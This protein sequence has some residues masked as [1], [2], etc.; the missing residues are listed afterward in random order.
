MAEVVRDEGGE[1]GARSSTASEI[2][3]WGV[4]GS[5]GRL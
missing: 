2:G 4:P 1:G 5:H 3:L